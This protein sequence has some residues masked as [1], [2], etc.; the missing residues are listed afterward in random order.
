M[1]LSD[2]GC[3]PGSTL[4]KIKFCR[5]VEVIYD[6]G[7]IPVIAHPYDIDIAEKLNTTKVE[8]DL[9]VNN[10]MEEVSKLSNAEVMTMQ[11]EEQIRF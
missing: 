9:Y 3:D 8:R 1:V 5:A 10:M 7:G 2:S 11:E 4:E 6:S